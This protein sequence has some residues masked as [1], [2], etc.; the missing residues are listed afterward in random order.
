M[1]A[2]P[3]F[4][5]LRVLVTGATGGIGHET[6]LALGQAGA[7]TLVHGRSADRV[8]GVIEEVRAGGGRAEGFVADLASLDDAARLARDVA[9]AGPVDAVINN[10]GIGF[11]QDRAARK[12]SLDGLELRFAVNYLAPFVLTEALLGLG[13]PGRAVIN[14]S[15]IGQE[16][17][18]FDDLLLTR[19][20]DGVRAYRR[21]KLAMILWT[22][23]LAE[24][25][26]ALRCHAL[27]PGTLL[28]T[29][30]VRDAGMVPRGA[31]Q[32]GAEATLFVLGEALSKPRSGLY[33]DQEREERANAQAYD[34]I[35][36]AK[37]REAT[38]ALVGR[39]L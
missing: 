20:Y 39:F 23:D 8:A 30:M 29:A 19:A 15:S 38:L 35:A 17:L 24:R 13:Q 33:F 28:D 4:T 10:A 9:R 32:R 14:V 2:T 36:R 26:P 1:T 21:S 7:V 6:A 27:H 12:V 34:S 31:P 18:D 11:G 22:F 3:S 25:V 37:L 5:D 16:P